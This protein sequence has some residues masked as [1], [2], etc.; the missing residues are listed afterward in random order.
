MNA[1]ILEL[2]SIEAG[3]GVIKALHEVSFSV[4]EGSF[5]AIVG[6]NGAGKTS[7]LNLIAGVV[8]PWEGSVWFNGTDITSLQ[9]Y[10]RVRL[11]IGLV[12]EGRRVFPRM[13][14]AENLA[15]GAHLRHDR[16]EIE[17]DRRQLIELF[18]ILG[19]RAQQL[20]G[21]LSGGE[22]QM[23]AIARALMGRPKLLLLDEPSMGVAP[24]L[25]QA[26][27]KAIGVLHQRG[28]T[29]LV[30]EQNAKLALSTAAEGFVIES[31]KLIL[32]GRSSE[33]LSNESVVR[34]YLG[35]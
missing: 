30:V 17:A 35:G 14:V 21:T 20:A 25:V 15:I 22:Q 18:P 6:A 4:E 24:L 31:G 29:I 1:P 3:Y 7:L 33:I 28:L 12:P 9:P 23:L 2:R 26:I 11:G 5:A 13:T 16:Q 8:A 10:E 32:R 34:A 27:F 19:E